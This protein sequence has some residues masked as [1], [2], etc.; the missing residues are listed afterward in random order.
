MS[1]SYASDR[2][3]P[4]AWL[5]DASRARTATRQAFTINQT[6][7]NDADVFKSDAQ[8]KLFCQWL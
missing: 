3:R 2:D 8:I 1:T 6:W 5:I 4:I 7:S